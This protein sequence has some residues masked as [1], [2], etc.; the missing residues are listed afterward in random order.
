[1]KVQIGY[2]P[3]H[4]LL[5]PSG[6]DYTGTVAVTNNYKT[7]QRWDT[8]TPHYSFYDSPADFP[9]DDGIVPENYC[10]NPKN[11]TTVWC[12]T[13]NPLVRWEWCAVP[14]CDQC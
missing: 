14:R 1:M 3:D 8:D 9:A 6:V 7:C 5:T 11:D 12:Y 10:R 4:C 13:T 2:F